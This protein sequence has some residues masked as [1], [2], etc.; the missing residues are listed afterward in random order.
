MAKEIDPT[1]KKIKQPTPPSP[2]SLE[3]AA[4]PPA[5]FRVQGQESGGAFNE[6]VQSGMAEFLKQGAP[7]GTHHLESP[8]GHTSYRI[9]TRADAK[10]KDAFWVAVAA[11]HKSAGGR[12]SGK[13]TAEGVYR[14]VKDESGLYTNLN[15]FAEPGGVE[16][17]KLNAKIET[18][19]PT[20]LH[21]MMSSETGRK[22]YHAFLI[23][24]AMNMMK[25]MKKHSKLKK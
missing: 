8:D 17:D 2:E 1:P 18:K 12:Q 4:V 3:E 19:I 9:A 14:V 24:I 16:V 21:E 25:E 7:M 23:Q 13:P 10:N 20:N 11:Y 5:G 15:V 22:I 6:S